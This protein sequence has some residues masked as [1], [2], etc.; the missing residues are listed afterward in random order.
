MS[1]KKDLQQRIFYKL[2]S[3][4]LESWQYYL[5][6]STFIFLTEI[7]TSSTKETSLVA[8]WYTEYFLKKLQSDFLQVPGSMILFAQGCTSKESNFSRSS[9][10][11]F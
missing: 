10:L 6:L 2:R 4:C 3:G 5:G 11:S 7:T 9:V 1:W 8:A